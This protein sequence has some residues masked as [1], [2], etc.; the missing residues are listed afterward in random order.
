MSTDSSEQGLVSPFHHS[1][2][3]IRQ[4]LTLRGGRDIVIGIVAGCSIH[5]AP[6]LPVGI[7]CKDNRGSSF[8]WVKSVALNVERSA[9]L[10]RNS[11]QGLEP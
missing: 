2:D 3:G 9:R 11:L 10:F 6:T 1:I 7:P 8:A 5:E 4:A